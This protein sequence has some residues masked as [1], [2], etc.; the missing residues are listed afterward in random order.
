M[1]TCN[2]EVSSS[3][4]SWAVVKNGCCRSFRLQS[5]TALKLEIPRT[6]GSCSTLDDRQG[7]NRKMVSSSHYLDELLIQMC[8]FRDRFT[9]H[10]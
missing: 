10:C 4:L 2:V 7:E 8:K 9:V 3:V 1:V 6:A 5:L